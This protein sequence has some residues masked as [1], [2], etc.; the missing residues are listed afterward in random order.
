MRKLIRGLMLSI[1][2]LLV[3]QGAV[4]HEL[5]H[6]NG[7]AQSEGDFRH[8]ND[9]ALCADC[10]AFSHVVFNAFHGDVQLPLFIG[11]TFAMPGRTPRCGT[12]PAGLP[13]RS[14]GPPVQL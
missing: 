11:L 12:T 9:T 4:M 5:G 14:R 13:A 3:Q 10:V 8:H 7:Q 1:V 2:L 6:L